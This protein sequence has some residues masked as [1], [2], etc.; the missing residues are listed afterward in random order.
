MLVIRSEGKRS[1]TNLS[2]NV[3]ILKMDFKEVGY[4]IAD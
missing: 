3:E 2:L 4:V 1:L